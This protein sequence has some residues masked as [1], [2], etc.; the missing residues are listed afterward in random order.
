MREGTATGPRYRGSSPGALRRGRLPVV[1]RRASTS[2]TA[3]LAVAGLLGSFLVPIT[4]STLGGLTHLVSCTAAVDQSFAI[5]AVDSRRAVVIGSSDVVRR[6]PEGDCAAV[7]MNMIVRPD[8]RGFVRIAIPVANMSSRAFRTTVK[9]RLGDLRIPVPV[10]V[11]EPGQ[12]ITKELRIRLTEDLKVVNG[13]LL[14]GP[15]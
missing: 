2:T 13:T 14:I 6:P 8:G 11:V 3:K 12:T 10:G 7:E 4:T 1:R 9:L 15:E 5:T